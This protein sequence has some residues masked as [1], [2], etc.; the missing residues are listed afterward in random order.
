MQFCDRCMQ[1]E[2]TRSQ[3][4]RSKFEQRVVDWNEKLFVTPP[5]LD[6]NDPQY[7]RLT[8]PKFLMVD[9]GPVPEVRTSA[10]VDPRDLSDQSPTAQASA[11]KPVTTATPTVHGPPASKSDLFRLSNVNTPLTAPRML[12]GSE[13]PSPKVDPWTG[14]EAPISSGEVVLKPGTKI[15]LGG[16]QGGGV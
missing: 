7:V 15:R 9:V 13:K 12:R 10:W 1:P 8:A 11:P 6:P 4:G 5:R 3:T 16:G 14:S 2:C